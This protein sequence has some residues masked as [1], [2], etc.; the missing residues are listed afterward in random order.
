MSLARFQ[1][2]KDPR[3]DTIMAGRVLCLVLCCWWSGTSGVCGFAAHPPEFAFSSCHLRRTIHPYSKVLPLH[4]SH[5]GSISA[6]KTINDGSPFP[7]RKGPPA[8]LVLNGLWKRLAVI[9]RPMLQGKSAVGT[10]LASSLFM[11]PSLRGGALSPEVLSR[12]AA[13]AARA[14]EGM[15]ITSDIVNEANSWLMNL[16]GPAALVAGAVVATLYENMKSGDLEVKEGEDSRMVTIMKK[17]TKLLL[18]SAFACEVMCIFVSFVT[19]TMLLSRS[20][21]MIMDIHTTAAETVKQLSSLSLQA[22]SEPTPLSFLRTHYEFEYLI[23]RITFLQGLFNWVAGIALGHATPSDSETEGTR[24]LN[25]FVAWSIVSCMILMLSF[26]NTHMTFYNNYFHMISR[27][28]TVVTHRFL[29]R[30]PPRPLIFVFVPSVVMS[31]Y[32][33]YKAFRDD[34]PAKG[35]A[36]TTKK[37]I[38]T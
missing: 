9:F 24:R 30:W 6:D 37:E 12:Q 33:G 31:L 13:A 10:A 1:F 21:K 34:S 15:I 19:G 20:N 38:T 32:T 14:A 8:S 16:G 36:K 17:T 22:I 18:L 4:Y 11:I 27:F 2:H 29:L 35:A 23:C 26:F 3:I 5:E 25:T 7:H 28:L